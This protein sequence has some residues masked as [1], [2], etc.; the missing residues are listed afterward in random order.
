MDAVA[1]YLQVL[2]NERRKSPATLRAYG[3][4]LRAFA[5]WLSGSGRSLATLA[6]A[7][8]RHYLVELE[9]R[10]LAATS[11]QRQLAS[12][13]GL[14]RWLQREGRIVTDPAKLLKG[15]RAPARVPRFLT[16]G[17][18]D[19]L[20]GQSFDESPQGRRDRA[21]LEVLY[22]TGCRV[23]ECAGTSLRHLDLTEG[24][25]RVLGKCG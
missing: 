4:D 11:V 20:L 3:T 7:D 16:A 23:S 24:V 8:L 12:L 1:E 10:G 22:S 15:P 2:A 21:I 17:E 18:V 6:R 14:C 13:R 9:Q 25:V 19:L 5:A